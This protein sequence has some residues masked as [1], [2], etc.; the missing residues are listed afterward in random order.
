LTGIKITAGSAYSASFYYRFPTSS[1]FSGNAVIGLQSSSGQ[2][3]ASATVA[4]SGQQT[5]W[6]QVTVTLTPSTS[7][8][9]LTNLF[10]VTLDGASA[11]G[12]TINFAMFSLFP[13]TFK[14]RANGMRVDIAEV[15]CFVSLLLLYLKILIVRPFKKW[16]L[17]SSV[18]QEV[19]I[20]RVRP[21]PLDGNGM[22]Q[23][24]FSLST[25]CIQSDTMDFEVGPILS[26][27]GNFGSIQLYLLLKHDTIQVEWATG[28][29]SIQSLC[30]SP[31]IL[32][33]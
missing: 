17:P 27:P 16:D 20:S 29:M 13:P 10:T 5:A 32:N 30:R 21:L 31:C 14:N 26:R 2:V 12:Q 33:V 1:S 25:F 6:K 24:A 28:A 19:T 11:S 7:A 3:F 9:A 8:S 4:L 22:Q 18:F 15:R 23:Y